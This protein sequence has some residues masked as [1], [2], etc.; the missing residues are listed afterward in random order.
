VEIVEVMELEERVTKLDKVL[1]GGLL[2]ATVIAGTV[3]ESETS[4]AHTEACTIPLA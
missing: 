2:E 1:T 4:A 3:V